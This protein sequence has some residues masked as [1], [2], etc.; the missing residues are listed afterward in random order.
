MRYVFISA[1]LTFS[2]C[3][4]DVPRELTR[5]DSYPVFVGYELYQRNSLDVDLVI[6]MYPE[7]ETLLVAA[8]QF[9]QARGPEKDRKRG[10]ITVRSADGTLKTAKYTGAETVVS[11]ANRNDLCTD[12]GSWEFLVIRVDPEDPLGR[13][14]VILCDLWK[15]SLLADVRQDISLFPGDF[16]FAIPKADP[17][18]GHMVFWKAVLRTLVNSGLRK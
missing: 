15:Y 11:I 8:P 6:S 10:K 7:F 1:L 2:A 18:K 5:P 9:I 4:S 13:S 17:D 12:P 3:A 16:L 14:R